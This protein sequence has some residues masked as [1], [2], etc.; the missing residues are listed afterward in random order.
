MDIH[1]IKGK[2]QDLPQQD[3]PQHDPLVPPALTFVFFAKEKDEKLLLWM[4]NSAF[5]ANVV[6]IRKLTKRLWIPAEIAMVNIIKI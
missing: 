2:Q 6:T 4:V 5:I 1:V 3:L